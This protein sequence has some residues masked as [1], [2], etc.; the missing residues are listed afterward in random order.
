MTV[1]SYEFGK[2]IPQIQ[3]L[4]ESG[5]Y[6]G[7]NTRAKYVERYAGQVGEAVVLDLNIHAHSSVYTA[8]VLVLSRVTIRRYFGSGYSMQE[9][10][11]YVHVVRVQHSRWV[12]GETV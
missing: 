2:T 12:P 10:A 3:D 4:K 7:Q 5:C 1:Q 6:C 8:L 9:S 11:G